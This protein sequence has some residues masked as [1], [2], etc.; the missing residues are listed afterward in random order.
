MIRR[1]FIVL[2]RWTGLLMAL[3]LI[4]VGLTGSLLAFNTELE[5]VFAPQLFA[6][7]RPGV[8]RLDFAT[9]AACAQPLVPK[10]R[11]QSVTLTEPDQARVDFIA[12][13]DPGTSRTY[14]LGFDDFFVDPWT[15]KELGRRIHGDLS[16]GRINVMPFV[17]DLHWRLAAGDLGQWILGIVALIWSL[18]CFVGFYLTLPRGPG[19]F[20]RRWKYAWRVKGSAGAFRV[21][22][23]LHR[24]GGLWTWAMLFIFGWS[25]VMMNIRPVYERVM[26]AVFANHSPRDTFMISAK[27]NDSPRLDWEAAQVVGERLVSEQSHLRG[28]KVNEPLGLAY[29]P[30]TGAYFYDARSN[31][32]VFERSPKG[33]TTSVMFDGDTGELRFLWQPTGERL[34]N[35]IESWLYALHMTRV[36]GRPYQIFVCFLGLAVALLSV[37]GVYIWW[38]KRKARVLAAGRAKSASPANRFGTGLNR[39]F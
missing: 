25:S 20:W 39:E 27:P 32:D 34:G 38:K 8:P 26:S 23:D 4:V 37:T 21:N 5:R 14:N 18:D 33:G 6:M 35:T 31:R 30:E 1:L 17:Y 7:P 13:T 12:R 16:Q 19:G 11:V 36:F 24:A 15:G 9:L 10:G 22:F 2:H 3:F 28:F 29:Y